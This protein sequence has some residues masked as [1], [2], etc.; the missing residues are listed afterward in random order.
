MKLYGKQARMLL[1]VGHGGHSALVTNTW[2]N[3]TVT[4]MQLLPSSSA[5][6]TPTSRWLADRATTCPLEHA[7][8]SPQFT[9]SFSA[10]INLVKIITSGQRN[11]AA[12]GTFLSGGEQTAF[13]SFPSFP[14]LEILNPHQFV[15]TPFPFVISLITTFPVLWDREGFWHTKLFLGWGILSFLAM[16]EN[17]R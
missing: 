6:F 1:L 10:L 9:E 7:T 14:P 2:W 3:A 15:V 16:W 13:F 12:P 8:T 4:R 11:S 5:K 17:S